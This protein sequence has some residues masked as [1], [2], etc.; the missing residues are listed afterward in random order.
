MIEIEIIEIVIRTQIQN[1]ILLRIH[2]QVQIKIRIQIRGNWIM[3]DI[4]FILII[5][6]L[7]KLHN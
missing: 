3:E 2:S 7:N 4:R 6:N 1:K 5:D